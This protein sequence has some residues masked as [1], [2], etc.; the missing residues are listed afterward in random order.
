MEKKYE[1]NY[2]K[3]NNTSFN[4]IIDNYDNNKTQMEKK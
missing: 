3:K 2:F 1:K 4:N